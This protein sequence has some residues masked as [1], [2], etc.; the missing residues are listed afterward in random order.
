MQQQLNPEQITLLI[1]SIIGAAVFFTAVTVGII[2]F[3][4]RVERGDRAEAA[5]FSEENEANLTEDE[6]PPTR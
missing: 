5:K 3:F 6:A 2:F 4:K 1:G